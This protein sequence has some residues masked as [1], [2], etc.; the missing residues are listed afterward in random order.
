[1]QLRD[2]MDRNVAVLTP[3]TPLREVVRQMS[4]TQVRLLPVCE[5]GKLVG[6]ITLR[7]LILRATAQGCDPE[8]SAA[9]EVMTRQIV[10]CC[11]DQDVNAAAALMAE[12]RLSRLPVLDRQGRLVGMITYNDLRKERSTSMA[13]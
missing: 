7:D 5:D 1:M 12:Y 6:M 9:H 3:D 4:T 13:A 10:Y 8:T 11:E 2:I